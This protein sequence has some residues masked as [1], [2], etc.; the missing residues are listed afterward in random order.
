LRARNQG[1]FRRLFSWRTTKR[2]QPFLVVNC[3]ECQT[4][5]NRLVVP[6]CRRGQAA[7]HDLAGC[8]ICFTFRLRL[9]HRSVCGRRGVSLPARSACRDQC[10][11]TSTASCCIFTAWCST[12]WKNS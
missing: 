12:T 8:G 11:K 10:T 5:L 7:P 9:L 1:A 2:Q 6:E 4:G 3:V